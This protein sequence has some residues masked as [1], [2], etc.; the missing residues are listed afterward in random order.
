MSRPEG[1]AGSGTHPD[2]SGADVARQFE[3]THLAGRYDLR[4][5]LGQ[6]GMGVVFLARDRVLNEDV[7]IKLLRTE[8]A[9]DRRWR[10]R[11]AREVKLARQLRH[12]NV[13]RLFDFGQT[14]DGQ[15][16]VVMELAS[17]TLRSEL[18]GAVNVQRTFADR[19]ADVC[20]VAAGLAAIHQA[21]IV[22]A[23][24]SS[25]YGLRC[26]DGRLIV[27]DVGLAG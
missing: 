7:A 6:G 25:R 15:V 27:A 4:R 22:H 13:C 23:D 12:P 19:I 5:A 20:A 21:G 11:L 3:G 24:L 8:L 16:F 10:E 9:G 17:H 2:H 26:G 18:D 14:E 1:F